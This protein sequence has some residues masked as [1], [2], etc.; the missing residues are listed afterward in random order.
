MSQTIIVGAKQKSVSGKRF[1]R[2]DDREA[3]EKAL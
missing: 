3:V 2:K 1:C